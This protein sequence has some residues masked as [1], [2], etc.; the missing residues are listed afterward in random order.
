[1]L[2][3]NRGLIQF[4]R[5][6]LDQAAAAYREAIRL[7]KD[8]YVGYAELARVYQKQSRTRPRSS[9]SRKQSRLN[10][11]GRHF[12]AVAPPW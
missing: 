10:W 5:G 8:S 7:R 6:R 2:Y 3:V 4:Q 1:M 9:N 11:I 12:I